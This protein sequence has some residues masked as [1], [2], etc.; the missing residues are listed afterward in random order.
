ME[1]EYEKVHESV[2]DIKH[3]IQ[4]LEHNTEVNYC[5]KV[6]EPKIME[7]E[8]GND[9]EDLV[10]CSQPTHTR[11]VKRRSSPV[12]QSELLMHPRKDAKLKIEKFKRGNCAR[13]W[14]KIFKT[15]AEMEGIA[16]TEW[17]RVMG[18]YMGTDVFLRYS[19]FKKKMKV[20]EECV[21]DEVI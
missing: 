5:G 4:R 17:A 10:E 12:E 1:E 9:N 8:S 3:S 7:L 14:L 20:L 15:S 6:F 21:K 18:K 16:V 2:K 11:T 13:K 19:D